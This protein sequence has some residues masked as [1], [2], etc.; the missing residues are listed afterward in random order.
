[1]ELDLQANGKVVLENPFRQVFQMEFI[2]DR[3]EQDV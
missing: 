2:E 3:R 1:M